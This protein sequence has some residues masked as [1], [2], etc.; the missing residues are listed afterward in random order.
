MIAALLLL[1]AAWA[2]TPPCPNGTS[3]IR[4]IHGHVWVPN[5]TAPPTAPQEGCEW[6]V[7]SDIETN[8]AAQCTSDNVTVRTCCRNG[9]SVTQVTEWVEA[10]QAWQNSTDVC[11]KCPA[12]RFSP[13]YDPMF[14]SATAA[15][16]ASWQPMA[17]GACRVCPHGKYSTHNRTHCDACAANE[18]T[19]RNASTSSADCKVCPSGEYYVFPNYSAAATPRKGCFP[20]WPNYYCPNGHDMRLCPLGFISEANDTTCHLIPRVTF[21]TDVAPTD[22]TVPCT[23]FQERADRKCRNSGGVNRWR[24][25]N[26]RVEMRQTYTNALD[27]HD[28]KDE[29]IMV[30]CIWC[31]GFEGP[32]G[33]AGD[34][35]VARFRCK[36]VDGKNTSCWDPAMDQEGS[37]GGA[38]R[39][40]RGCGAVWRSLLVA[41]A[42]LALLY[43]S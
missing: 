42:A 15:L 29:T 34:R 17:P 4:Y 36:A 14:I 22:A 1:D 23:T 13:N 18:H 8:G 30:R 20:C 26:L 32:V 40:A 19:E 35:C 41:L 38:G 12:G 39:F 16:N 43:G 2:Q 37:A 24:C 31:P 6:N 11:L 7:L 27:D 5:A 10:V 28:S 9:T 3:Q 21:D 33:P 25:N